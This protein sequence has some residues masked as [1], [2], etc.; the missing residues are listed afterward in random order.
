VR[1]SGLALDDTAAISYRLGFFALSGFGGVYP[2]GTHDAV[3]LKTGNRF[4]LMRG[5]VTE[6]LYI[7]SAIGPLVLVD[8]K[9]EHYCGFK[10]R[11]TFTTSLPHIGAFSNWIC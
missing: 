6:V 8:S 2:A 1:H 5:E 10:L 3:G 7:C 11:K 4:F 9:E